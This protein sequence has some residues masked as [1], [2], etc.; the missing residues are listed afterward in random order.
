MVKQGNDIIQAFPVKA[1]TVVVP[2]NGNQVLSGEAIIHVVEDG[3]ITFHFPSRD[4][5]LDVVAGLD[6]AVMDGCESIDTTG[7]V[8]VS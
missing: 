7:A 3:T 4:V 6:L 8:W 2:A 5:V 1:G